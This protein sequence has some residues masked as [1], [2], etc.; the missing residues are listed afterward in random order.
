[1]IVARGGVGLLAAGLFFPMAMA[2]AMN[3]LGLISDV[4]W[5]WTLFYIACAQ[6]ATLGAGA[7]FHPVGRAI[8]R[9]SSEVHNHFERL[10]WGE[11]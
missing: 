11:R 5:W 1:M 8:R 6:L 3:M 4:T 2:G 10:A 7:N 9:W